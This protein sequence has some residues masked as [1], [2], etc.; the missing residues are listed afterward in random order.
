[1]NDEIKNARALTQGKAEQ[2]PNEFA[3]AVYVPPET[4][5]DLE[6]IQRECRVL[7][8]IEPG[9]YPQPGELPDFAPMWEAVERCTRAMNIAADAFDNLEIQA[10][11]ASI[12]LGTLAA[13][14]PDLVE[15]E[16]AEKSR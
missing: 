8:R 11:R 2:Q 16:D 13:A 5:A 1:M 14:M 3:H 9:G 6:A 10:K 12:A 4:L 15:G 7:G